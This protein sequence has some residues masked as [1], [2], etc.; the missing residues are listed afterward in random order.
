MYTSDD[1]DNLRWR[2]FAFRDGDIVISTRSKHG[3]TWVQQICALLL[4][5]GPDLPAPLAELSPWVDWLIEPRDELFARLAAQPHRRLLKSH[6][7]L[8]GLPQDARASYVVVARHPLD[9]AVSLYHQGANLD[10]GRIAA[11]SGHP[12]PKPGPPRPPVA[13][14]L[15]EWTTSTVTHRES[16]ESP[17]GVLH[18]VTDAWQRR[19]AAAADHDLPRVVLVHY[20]DLEADLAG[21]MRRL[22]AALDLPVTEERLPGLVAAAGFEAM[23]DAAETTAPDPRGVLRSRAAFFRSGGSGGGQALLGADDVAAFEVRCRELAPAPV[24][25]WLLR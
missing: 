3:T 4:F 1:D 5:G 23:K 18:H 15:R 13:Q 25:D 14:W 17:A 21:E 6:T 24:V 12:A 20:A 10:R 11:L 9:G 8:D 19:A 16:L 2:G 7:P 22:A